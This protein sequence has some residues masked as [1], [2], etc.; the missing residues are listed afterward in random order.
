MRGWGIRSGPIGRPRME[1]RFGEEWVGVGRRDISRDNLCR[2][3][4]RSR[5]G[6]ARVVDE[7]FTTGELLEDL[8]CVERGLVICERRLGQDTISETIHLQVDVPGLS[9]TDGPLSIDDDDGNPTDATLAGFF[10]LVFNRL[11]VFV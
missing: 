11:T 3:G 1:E 6:A 9:A 4:L 10:D 5:F 7:P 8:C 2:K